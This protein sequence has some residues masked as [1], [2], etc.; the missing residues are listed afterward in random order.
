ME[1]TAVNPITSFQIG[2]QM[3]HRIVAALILV[4][5][6]FCAWGGHGAGDGNLNLHKLARVWFLLIL[7]QAFLGAATIWSN[8]AADIAT[9]HVV[10][11]ALSLAMGAIL[12]ILASRGSGLV[13]R[14]TLASGATVALPQAPFEPRRPA[15]AGLE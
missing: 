9:A 5:V 1:S 12:T 8:K 15:A 14:T 13:G 4:A 11:G 2:L 6:A 10:I 3:A 7:S